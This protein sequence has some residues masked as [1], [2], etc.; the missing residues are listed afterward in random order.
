MNCLF[1]IIFIFTLIN[2]F[3]LAYKDYKE[4][5]L[6]DTLN[7]SL[8]ILGLALNSAAHWQIISV[9][10]SLSGALGGFIFIMSI[11]LIADKFYKP[12][13]VG[14]GDVKLI[15]AAGFLLGIPNIFMAISLGAFLGI[16]HGIYSARKNKTELAET[17]IPAGV[18]LCTAIAI[19][20]I[21]NSLTL[22]I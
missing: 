18:G 6:P 20:L 13:S 4:Y 14:L 11:K 15:S 16:M 12:D 5:I 2:L 9:V 8:A 3:A 7:F 21:I 19:S 1:P 17:Q 22:L 10:S